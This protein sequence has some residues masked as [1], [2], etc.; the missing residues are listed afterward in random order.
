MVSLQRASYI[1]QENM[2]RLGGHRCFHRYTS[3]MEE[4]YM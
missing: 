4:M 1:Y 3:L 2:M